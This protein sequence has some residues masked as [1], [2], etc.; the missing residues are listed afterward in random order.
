MKTSLKILV[1]E[2]SPADFMLVERLL[3]QN[4]LEP[5]CMRVSTNA[6]LEAA[7]QG[8]WDLILSDYNVPGMDFLTTLQ[9]IQSLRPELPAIMV[10]GSVGEE[11]AVE[12]LRMG[13]SDF[14]LKDRL[15]RLPAVIR[16]TLEEANERSARQAAEKALL[17][18]Q[19]ATLQAQY[20]ARQAALNLMEDAIAARAR[21]EAANTALRES[22]QR[23]LLAQ[24][25]AHV[26]IWEFDILSNQSYWSPEF[27]RLYGLTPSGRL[28]DNDEWRALVHPDDLPLIDAQW[29]SHIAKGEA[30]EVEFRVRLNSGETRWMVSKGRAHYNTE[31]KPVRLSGINLDITERKQ[32]EEQ[33]IKLAQAVEQSPESIII[34][35]LNGEIEYANEA[36][37]RNSGFGFA[38]LIGRNPRILKSGKTPNTSYA[39]L[40]ETL[41]RGHTWKGEFVNKR[42]NGGEYVVFAIITPIRQLN[43][44]ITHYVAVQEDITEKKRIAEELEQHRHH[45]ETLVESRT[46]ELEAA[47]VIADSANQAKT[48]FLANMSHEIRTP[49]NAIIGLTYLLRQS[50][51]T[52]EQRSRLDKIDAAGQHL[53]SI[54]NDI[55]DLSK[56]EA[57]RLEL[58]QTDF[59]LETVLDHVSSLIAAQAR[60]KGLSIEVASDGVPIWLRGDP[61][62]LRQAV[63]NYAGNAIKFTERGGIRLQSKL[64]KETGEGLLV[65]FAVQDT[66]I[67]I[68][69]ENL[70]MLFDAFTQSDV[71]TT[72]KYGGTGLGLSIT[73]HLANMMGGEV[74]VESIPGQGSTFWFTVLLQRGHGVMPSPAM[75]NTPEAAVLLRRDYAGARLLLAEDNPINRE[76][77]LELLHGAGLAVDTA[78][79]GEVAVEKVLANNYDLVL[80]DVQMPKMD[81]LEATRSIRRKAGHANPPILAMTANAFDEDRNNC[82]AAGMNDFVAKPV[83]PDALYATLLRWLSAAD[84]NLERPDL[85]K[86]PPEASAC[87]EDT[88]P[89]PPVGPQ[90][91]SFSIPGLEA[92]QGLAVVKGD[93]AKYLRLLRMFAGSHR[94]DMKRVLAKLADNDDKHELQRLTHGLKG[95]AGTLGARGV[96]GLADKL[97]RA[98]RQNAAYAECADLAK[99]CDHELTLLIEAILA[100]SEQSAFIENADGDRAPER[101]AAILAELENLLAENNIRASQLAEEHADQL[102]K[103]LGGQYSNFTRLIDIFE[104]EDALEILRKPPQ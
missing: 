35:N 103:K 42:K 14:V 16:R 15:M 34:T 83:N 43:G 44:R 33:L 76:V 18:S 72:R 39:T 23:L 21:A 99:Q 31:G 55:L 52:S 25:A 95:V 50:N 73:R 17:E 29:D 36:Y 4:G 75:E 80:M 71:S 8:Q 46:A 32:T 3:S 65:R 12:L 54:I 7:L 66:G 78:E 51:L 30:F 20:Q 48:A 84:C 5:E 92:A 19:A 93:A 94:D 98:L 47:R 53:L 82:I 57:G 2:D 67:G 85:K 37:Q 97:D 59:S 24:E 100:W 70:P 69:K 62:R 91:Q 88:T 1:I 96:Y 40:W 102:R 6:E 45:L 10:S 41:R 26:G 104:Y 74:G 28:H 63:L 68:A 101:F 22:E 58:E 49:M 79:N 87:M 77:A 27:E 90:S 61:T 89:S 56:I 86:S 81:G 9:R 60:E 13:L 64:L 11:T 38:E